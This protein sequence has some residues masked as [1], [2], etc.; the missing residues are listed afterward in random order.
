MGIVRLGLGCGSI[1]TMMEE[2]RLRRKIMEDQGAWFC[3]DHGRLI[4]TNNP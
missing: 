4:S 1:K 3:F 2:K